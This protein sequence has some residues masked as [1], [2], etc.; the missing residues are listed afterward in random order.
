MVVVACL[1]CPMR[2]LPNLGLA[3]VFCFTLMC[4]CAAFRMHCVV[5]YAFCVFACASFNVFV[6]GVC[7]FVFV[8]WCLDLCVRSVCLCVVPSMWLCVLFV[9][10]RVMSH[11]L[12]FVCCVCLRV[13]PILVC[14][15]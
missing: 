1:R 15:L 10:Y 6:R 3:G 9:I 14:C 12:F 11:G 7:G 8:V 13:F 4:L 5:L 2:S